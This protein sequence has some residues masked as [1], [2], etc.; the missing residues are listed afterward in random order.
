[1]AD[2]RRSSTAAAHAEK[3]FKKAEEARLVH[4]QI[5][6]EAVKR[7]ANT[8]RLKALRME[9]DRLESEAAAAAPKPKPKTKA[10]AKPKKP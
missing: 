6:E 1:M 9:R 5:D 10:K 4:Q 7:E 8:A 2:E 3:A